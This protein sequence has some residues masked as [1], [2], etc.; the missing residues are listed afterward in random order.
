MHSMC[1][2]EKENGLTQWTL[3]KYAYT[4]LRRL[5]LWC[6]VGPPLT[7]LSLS[8]Y[9]TA[10]D[11][12]PTAVISTFY[13]ALTDQSAGRERGSRKDEELVKLGGKEKCRGEGEQREKRRM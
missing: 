7:L 10:M 5:V 4:Q 6:G 8:Q 11:Y 3:Y 13:K 1:E 12:P 9:A 2:K